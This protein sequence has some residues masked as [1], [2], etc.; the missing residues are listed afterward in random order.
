[1][2]FTRTVVEQELVN[3]VA[4][5]LAA[6]GLDSTATGTNTDLNA[7]IRKSLKVLSISVA[8][9]SNVSNADLAAVTSDDFEQLID[10]AEL[11]T[12]KVIQSN[13]NKVDVR[14]GPA[15]TNYSQLGERIEKL[16]AAKTKDVQRDYGK[17]VPMLETGTIAADF[18]ARDTD[19]V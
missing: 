19:D 10:I 5:L 13:L 18:M 12:L 11:E 1:M 4:P 14:L 2:S 3:R 15:A 17:T 6:V 9:V 16:I 8:D 7:P